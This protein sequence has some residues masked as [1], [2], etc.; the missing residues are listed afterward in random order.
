[1]NKCTVNELDS[2]H[3]A[4]QQMPIELFIQKIQTRL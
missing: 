3:S 4:I 2:M 1:M